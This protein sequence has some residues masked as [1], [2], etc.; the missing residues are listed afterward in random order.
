MTRETYDAYRAWRASGADAS[1][2]AFNPYD[3]K[4]YL[5]A[6]EK[7]P[8]PSG[9]SYSPNGTGTDQG[10]NENSKQLLILA[11]VGV[12]VFLLMK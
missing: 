2:E 3:A 10:V 11:A 1:G 5:R 4:K 9:Y 6:V 7:N 12:G 8:Q